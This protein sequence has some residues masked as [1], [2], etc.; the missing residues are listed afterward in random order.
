MR[1]T[2]RKR[3]FDYEEY[4]V[5]EVDLGASRTG[6][7]LAILFV[8][9]VVAGSALAYVRLRSRTEACRQRLVQLRREYE[10][11]R[12]ELA[13]L[14]IQLESYTTVEHVRAAVAHFG[15]G[16]HEPYSGQV[17][18]VALPDPVPEN[19]DQAAREPLLARRSN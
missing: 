1:R 13:N 19:P 17:R 14:E 16:L 6:L 15:L 3:S 8:L 10:V 11:S 9:V 2:T 12:K 5:R 7:V 4:P 18:R